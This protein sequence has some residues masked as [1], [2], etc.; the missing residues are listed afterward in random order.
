MTSILL[1][2]QHPSQG[3][4]CVRQADADVGV[5]LDGQRRRHD[6]VT[7]SRNGIRLLHPHLV[8]L[9]FVQKKRFKYYG[10]QPTPRL[11]ASSVAP[12]QKNA[13]VLDFR[14]ACIKKIL[15]F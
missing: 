12:R 15:V 5:R 6:D 2:H 14:L 4:C 10:H 1:V 8:R 9:L 11:Q 13:I 3:D 7:K